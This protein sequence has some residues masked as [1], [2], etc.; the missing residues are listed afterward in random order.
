MACCERCAAGELQV[1]QRTISSPCFLV[2]AIT[3]CVRDMPVCRRE[4]EAKQ[5][6]AGKQAAAKQAKRKETGGRRA[7]KAAAAAGSSKE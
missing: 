1:W 6:K 5:F 3:I 7:S 2:A 4:E